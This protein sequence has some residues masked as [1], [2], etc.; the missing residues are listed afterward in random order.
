MT[1]PSRLA[2]GIAAIGLTIPQET[3]TLLLRYLALIQKWNSVYNLT[4]LRDPETM[5]VRHLLDSLAIAPHIDGKRI[6]DVGSG[7]GSA[8]N[9]I[10]VGAS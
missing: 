6:A 7:A 4:A 3:Q 5:L 8:R 2:D 10:G 1:L 9:T